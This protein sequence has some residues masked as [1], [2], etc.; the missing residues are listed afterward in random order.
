MAFTRLPTRPLPRGGLVAVIIVLATALSPA[1]SAQSS[2]VDRL[3]NPDYLPS[4]GEVVTSSTVRLRTLSW[5]RL[6]R[7]GAPVSKSDQ[8]INTI[9]QEVSLGITEAL[10]LT[11]AQSYQDIS[12]RT[13]R[14]NGSF[15]KTDSYGFENPQIKATWR[16]YRQRDASDFPNIDILA[17]VAPD[18][19]DGR[20]ATVDK[21]GNAANGNTLARAGI[22]LSGPLLGNDYFRIYAG[23]FHI[24]KARR[25]NPAGFDVETDSSIRYQL[26]GRY[27]RYLSDWLSAGVFAGYTH[28]PGTLTTRLSAIPSSTLRGSRNF[29][30]AGITLAYEFIPNKASISFDYMRE[31]IDDV[32]LTN[33]QTNNQF[34]D[35][36]SASNHFIIRAKF[37]M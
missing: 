23:T 34:S 16:I 14:T 31:W 12:T 32:D 20:I 5:T 35:V 24:G 10:A 13:T 26:Q 29:Y 2:R 17:D 30:N 9:T 27:V 25:F 6:N 7:F 19:L 37:A 33:I 4:K 8:G 11:F 22:A 21:D 18:L 36:D 3:S 28:D 1:A 15:S